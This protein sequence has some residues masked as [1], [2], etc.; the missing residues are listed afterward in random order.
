MS[1]GKTIVTH[2][3]LKSGTKRMI[4]IWTH[5]IH[6]E[7]LPENK[8]NTEESKIEQGKDKVLGI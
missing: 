1:L 4:D 7:Y 8:A 3:Y 5:A 2:I 6:G